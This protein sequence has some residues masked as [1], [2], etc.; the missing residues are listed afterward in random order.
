MLC[1]LVTPV[2]PRFESS[3]S[4]SWETWLFLQSLIALLTEERNFFLL[5]CLFVL[6]LHH[7]IIFW[8]TLKQQLG[9]W[10]SVKI[11]SPIQITVRK[12]VIYSPCCTKCSC[13]QA[14]SLV[15]SQEG[16]THSST[17]WLVGEQGLA[18]IIKAH[19]N[20]RNRKT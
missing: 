2:S 20:S 13:V 1:E 3:I 7:N 4:Y 11:L 14:F 16:A 17:W 5:F 6:L 9:I 10:S 12:K 8:K 18:L 15:V 19:F